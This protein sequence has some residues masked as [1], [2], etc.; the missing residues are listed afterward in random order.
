MEEYIGSIG[1]GLKFFEFSKYADE[2]EWYYAP[3]ISAVLKQ[4]FQLLL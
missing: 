4:T 1:E 2:I 3:K